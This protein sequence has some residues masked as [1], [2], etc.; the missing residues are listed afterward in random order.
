M[1]MRSMDLIRF[2]VSKENP[3]E[4]ELINRMKKQFLNTIIIVVDGD[5]DREVISKAFSY[6]A[7]DASRR[8]YKRALIAER[9]K[10]LL[11]RIS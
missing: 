4:V 2:G 9:V 3:A 5:H 7:K 10:A 11:S 1:A 8:P 6:G